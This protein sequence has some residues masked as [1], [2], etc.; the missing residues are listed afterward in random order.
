MAAESLSRRPVAALAAGAA[1]ISFA[2][3]L[4]KAAGGSGLA[5]TAIA[6]WRCLLGATI[7]VA[8]AAVR[9]QP[10]DTPRE[11]RGPLLAAGLAFA[12]D[13]FVWHRSIVLAGA[14]MATILG[15][16]QVFGTATLSALL[17][18]E[19]LTPR[20]VLAAV[21]AMA[22]VVL[23]VGVG[24]RIEFTADYVAGVA[25]GLA[26][27]LAYAVFLVC[28]RTAGRRSR[29]GSTMV[30]LAWLS[31][32]ASAALGVMLGAEGAAIWPDDAA[33]WVYLALLALIAQ[34]L[35]WWTISKSLTH[36][37][38]A[39]GGL[40]LLM[41]PVLATVWGVLLFGER[42]EPLQILGAA[43]TLAAIAV[44]SAGDR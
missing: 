14:G 6:L 19:R 4:V 44:G 8:A 18:R 29:G 41:Q 10:L 5:P 16:T 24:S 22:G 13:L 17:F 9:R 31:I 1:L 28:L 12:V 26:T 21:A 23:L 42:L 38:G 2:P 32:Y 37:E 20:F 15:A 30:R 39:T 7:L 34:S 11:V 27:G 33:T 36:V 35:G 3:I 40:V 25:Y 43:I